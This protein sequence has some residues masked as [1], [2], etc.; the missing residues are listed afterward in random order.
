MI[1]I[2]KPARNELQRSA[3]ETCLS[4]LALILVSHKISPFRLFLSLLLAL[5]FCGLA[6]PADG[7]AERYE[8]GKRLRRFELAWEQARPEKQKLATPI[9]QQ[10][11]TS[12]FSLQLKNAASQLDEAW[13]VVSDQKSADWQQALVP[14][15]IHISSALIQ[16]DRERSEPDQ[17]LGNSDELLIKM[18]PFY[19]AAVQVPEPVQM[20][21]LLLNADEEVLREFQASWQTATTGLSIPLS[22]FPTGDYR[23]RAQADYEQSPF[24]WPEMGF[25]KIDRLEERLNRLQQAIQERDGK[26][27][28]T[29]RASLSEYHDLIRQAEEPF[30]LET[31]YPLFRLLQ[32]AESVIASADPTQTF[33]LT[34][35]P[36]QR[37]A[38][39]ARREDLW[40][41]LA[42]GRRRV[43]LRVRAPR[44]NLEPSNTE[45]P[46]SGESIKMPVLFLF[47]GAGGSENM[48]FETYG[49]GKTVQMGLDRGWL[50][51]AP[52]QGLMGL[53]LDSQQ[54]LNA[55]EPFFN[56]DR[57][58]VYFLGHSMGA[59]QVIRQV[60]LN[61]E[62]PRAAA[63]IG[64]GRPIRDSAKISAVPWFVSAGELD[65]GRAGAQSFHQSLKN[66]NAADAVYV[67]YPDIEHMV[68]VQAALPKAFEFF[69]RV[70]K[71]TR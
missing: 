60:Q 34:R 27:N 61:P 25:S 23:I 3:A 36:E 64:G 32:L 53:S 57:E 68:I 30:S 7:Q 33:E 8:L 42:D 6:S 15:R 14:Y 51:V 44:Q 22:D 28:A 38:E 43:P 26:L 2:Q 58:Q 16:P 50:V 11:V 63:A 49:A 5:P 24:P 13:W 21:F 12:F 40:M 52:R 9:M 47:H 20:R 62:L 46:A 71:S 17:G 39:M 67:E 29:V 56:I 69:D 37:F 1:P 59:A 35:S 4:D 10:A 70:A 66:A 55:L 45:G 41:V 65:F 54:M 18:Q 19:R 31:D 48:F